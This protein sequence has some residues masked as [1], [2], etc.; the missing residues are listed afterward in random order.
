MARLPG[1][2]LGSAS[3]TCPTT[4]MVAPSVFLSHLAGLPDPPVSGCSAAVTRVCSTSQARSPSPRVRVPSTS[5]S[6]LVGT[7]PTVAL[8]RGHIGGWPPRDAQRLP[9]TGAG[10]RPLWIFVSAAAGLVIAASTGGR[11]AGLRRVPRPVLFGLQPAGHA[12]LGRFPWRA[13]CR[14]CSGRSAA[15]ASGRGP[16]LPRSSSGPGTGSPSWP[17]SE[18]RL[19]LARDMHDLTGQSLS[20]ITLKSDLAIKRARPA[21]RFGRRRTRSA[22]SWRTSAG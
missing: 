14:W 2:P 15:S 18:E 6:R 19:R 12:R 3:R 4:R 17:P 21:A 16:L 22:A 10:P 11:R 7:W 13:C 1:R 8:T 5:P 20:M 9:P